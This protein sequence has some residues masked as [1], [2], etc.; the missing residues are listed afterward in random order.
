M[1]KKSAQKTGAYVPE[2]LTQSAFL[3]NMGII[4][5]AQQLLE[6]DKVTEEEANLLYTY[7]MTLI[8]PEKMGEK[9]KVLSVVHPN[10]KNDIPGFPER[11]NSLNQN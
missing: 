6:S 4:E 10:Y 1:C 5:R 9:F 11:N 7:L 2:V 3:M 8:S